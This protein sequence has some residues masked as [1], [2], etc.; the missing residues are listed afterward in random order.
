MELKHVNRVVDGVYKCVVT[1]GTRESTDGQPHQVDVSFPV[2]FKAAKNGGYTLHLADEFELNA[3]LNGMKLA[4]AAKAKGAS[5]FHKAGEPLTE[6]EKAARKVERA[7][8]S[9]RARLEKI[10][11]EL[12]QDAVNEVLAAA[13]LL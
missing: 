9:V 13:G 8:K 1:I 10:K 4:A 2:N 6:E 11:E 5:G 3:A 12:G 7:K